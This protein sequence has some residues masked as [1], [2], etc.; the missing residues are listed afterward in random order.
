MRVIH[1]KKSGFHIVFWGILCLPTSSQ[2][3]KTIGPIY[4]QISSHSLATFQAQFPACL[5]V[6]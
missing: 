4:K 2:H 3:L 6:N 5:P 1:L